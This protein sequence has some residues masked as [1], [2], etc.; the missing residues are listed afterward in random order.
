MSS[1]DCAY[2][3]LQFHTMINNLWE[4]KYTFVVLEFIIYHFAVATLE[5]FLLHY[6]GKVLNILLFYGLSQALM[7]YPCIIH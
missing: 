4:N 1:C 5:V 6:G 3:F 7:V 2:M